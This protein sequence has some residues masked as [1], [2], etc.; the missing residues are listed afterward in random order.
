MASLTVR[1]LDDEVKRR[2]RLRAAHH[3]RSMEAEVRAILADSVSTARD[4]TDPP[5]YGF[6]TWLHE[7]FSELGGLEL[8]VPPRTDLPRA[9]SFD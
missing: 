2:L 6:G 5:E 9:A 7:Q 8:K 1:D 3:G 4:H